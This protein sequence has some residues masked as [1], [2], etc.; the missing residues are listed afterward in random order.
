MPS[1]RYRLTRSLASPSL[2]CSITAYFRS[3]PC[4]ARRCTSPACYPVWPSAC[5]GCGSSNHSRPGQCCAACYRLARS[6]LGVFPDRGD[7]IPGV[8]EPVGRRSI[9]GDLPGGSAGPSAGCARSSSLDGAGS[10][11]RLQHVTIP[12]VSPAILFNLV[13]D[14]ISNFQVFTQAFVVT[15]SGGTLVQ[16]ATYRACG[17]SAPLPDHA[18]ASSAWWRVVRLRAERTPSRS[19]ILIAA[20]L[21][22]GGALGDDYPVGERFD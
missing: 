3:K 17:A 7:S 13:L 2:C 22:S 21:R 19:K 4:F 6:T 10:L 11:A 16:A 9:Y 12:L 1:W 20:I 14:L 8:D 15:S 18:P 5:F